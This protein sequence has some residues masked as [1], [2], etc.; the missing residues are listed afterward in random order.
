[1]PGRHGRGPSGAEL[2]RALGS[3]AKTPVT[4][5][6][7]DQG[8]SHCQAIRVQS[9]AGGADFMSPNH[10]ARGSIKQERAV[11]LLILGRRINSTRS[12]CIRAILWLKSQIIEI[13]M[14]HPNQRAVYE[15]RKRI[16]VEISP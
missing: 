7:S 12:H 14:L 4:A 5:R 3:P 9:H 6:I 16:A 10:I 11:I 1:M 13:M 2:R 8:L 15:R